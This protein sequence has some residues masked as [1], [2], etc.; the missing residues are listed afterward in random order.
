[1]RAL[2]A[3]IT[4]VLFPL[5]AAEW[6]V[7]PPPTGDD[8]NPGTPAEP[9]A[10]IQAAADQAGPGDTVYVAAGTY[11]ESVRPANSGTASAPIV[12]RATGAVIIDGRDPITGWSQR[13][14]RWVAPMAGDFF[15]SATPGD[16]VNLYDASVYNQADQIFWDDTMLPVAR[17]PND[18]DY[19]PSLPVKAVSD[20]FISRTRTDDNWTET[21]MRDGDFDLSA[22]QAVGAEIVLQP[23][24]GGW[25]WI[26]S[27][28]ITAVDGD[29]FTMRTRSG[30]GEQTFNADRYHDNSRYVIFNHPELLDAAGEWYHDKDAGELLLQTPDGSNPTGR[31][32]AKR[33]CFGFDCSDRSHI[34]I[35]GFTLIGCTVTTDIGAG[36]D[37]IGYTEGGGKRYPWRNAAWKVSDS[38]Y[39][40]PEEYKDAPSSHVV[41]RDLVVHYPTHYTD[42]SGHFANQWGQSSGLMVSGRNHEVRNC[43]VRYSA[44]SGI[45]LLGRN[46]RVIGNLVEDTNYAVT[47][48]GA[49]DCGHSSR[50]S[51]DHEIAY[52]TVR[53]TGRSALNLNMYRSDPEDPNSPARVHHNDVSGFGMQ[54]W[55]IGGTY[56]GNDNRFLRIDHNIFHNAWPDVDG[57]EGDGCFTASGVYPDYGR[58]LIIDHN[59]IVDVEWGIH[60]QNQKGGFDTANFLILHNT[61]AVKGFSDPLPPY[62]PFGVVTNS[63]ANQAG[64]VVRGNVAWCRNDS[65]KF[66]HIDFTH[67]S[68]VPR[69]VDHNLWWDHVPGSATDPALTGGDALPHGF[70]PTSGSTALIDG[71]QDYTTFDRDGFTVP[72]PMDSVNG[73]SPDIGAYEYGTLPWDAGH[74]AT[75]RISVQTVSDTEWESVEPVDRQPSAPVGGTQ[76]LHVGSTE[77]VVLA[78]L[79]DNNG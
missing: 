75:R 22:S 72:V 18:P 39:H 15:S 19:D 66:K 59:L 50:C 35:R 32:F 76:V 43:H 60:I 16:G 48:C 26:V 40:Q 21:V 24:N 79:G 25:S 61:I 70:L 12:Y 56:S 67:D 64:T 33:R 41:L 8:A 55:D 65:P 7:A 9:L 36:G 62:G 77:T 73:A 63:G 37:N 29:K 53:R 5:G 58:N 20:E 4:L 69:L 68:D 71:A 51:S 11:R 74:R 44:G 45:A 27:G 2:A 10:T 17:W 6:H 42:V 49:I 54:D 52:N 13:D 1:M 31:V 34:E 30:A 46:H 23:N 38:P 78:P 57:I 28:F 47:G 3:L 14:G